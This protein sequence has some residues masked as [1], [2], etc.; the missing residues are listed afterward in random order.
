MDGY[1]VL[2]W[3]L[4]SFIAGAGVGGWVAY[5]LMSGGSGPRV[6]HMIRRGFQWARSDIRIPEPTAENTLIRKVTDWERAADLNIVDRTL[7]FHIQDTRTGL[8]RDLTYSA[9]MV[10]RFFKCDTPVRAEWHGDN[11]DYTRLLAIGKGYGWVIPDSGRYS[12]AVWLSTRERRLRVLES[13]LSAG[14]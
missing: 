11:N 9:A 2:A 14:L 3:A 5:R 1:A 10:L 6:P 13:W 7:T 4:G 8:D 12:W